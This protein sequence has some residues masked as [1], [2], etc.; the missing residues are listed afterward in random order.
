MVS[1]PAE[2]RDDGDGSLQLAF[3]FGG[4]RGDGTRATEEEAFVLDL[5]SGGAAGGSGGDEDERMIGE[6]ADAD[7]AQVGLNRKQNCMQVLVFRLPISGR[8][9]HHSP[10]I[11]KVEV[12]YQLQP[13]VLHAPP[14]PPPST[15]FPPNAAAVCVKSRYAL[16][17]FLKPDREES[18]DVHHL[19]HPNT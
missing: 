9:P 17:F 7:D 15:P 18:W 3:L 19:V 10:A 8:F 1:V 12:A 14:S 5:A 13:C 4:C 16:D 11:S 6:D 2:D